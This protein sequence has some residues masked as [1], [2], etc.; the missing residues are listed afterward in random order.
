M[1]YAP[2]SVWPEETITMIGLYS[3]RHLGPPLMVETM[4]AHGIDFERVPHTDRT[5]A[6]TRCLHCIHTEQCV[7]WLR[8]L[9]TAFEQSRFCPNAELFGRLP[10]KAVCELPPRR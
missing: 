5:V 8:G 4:K 6:R 10:R 2:Y 1:G 7:A 9:N 3:E